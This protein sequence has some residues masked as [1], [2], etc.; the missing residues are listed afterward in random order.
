MSWTGIV[1]LAGGAYLF[2]ALGVLV[3]GPLLRR[4]S[5]A[6]GDQTEAALG[7]P[8]RVGQLLPPA[9]LAALVVSQTVATGTELVIDARLAGV[10]AGAVAVW[11]K[12]PFW[13]V[14]LIAAAVTAGVRAVA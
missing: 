14:L 8:I 9:L 11:R 3:V 2:K 1:I 10:A 4:G 6:E 7:W 12:A 13:L 5:A